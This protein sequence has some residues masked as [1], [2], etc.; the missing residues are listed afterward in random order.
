MFCFKHYEINK[1]QLNP[2]SN[3]EKWNE[4]TTVKPKWPK[5]RELKRTIQKS[6]RDEVREDEER[7]RE[8]KEKTQ[9]K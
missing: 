4:V 5:Y 1:I 8:L 3:F 2:R 6:I 9:I 7:E